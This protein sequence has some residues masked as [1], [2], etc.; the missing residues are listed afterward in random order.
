MSGKINTYFT[1]YI[2]YQSLLYNPNIFGHLSGVDFKACT[3]FLSAN[4]AEGISRRDKSFLS[5]K[6]LQLSLNIHISPL[7]G[8]FPDM[9]A[10]EGGE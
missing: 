5:F 9:M 7:L 2:L 10:G 4:N 1:K 6:I 8:K 3:L